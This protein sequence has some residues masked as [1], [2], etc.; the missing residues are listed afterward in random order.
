MTLLQVDAL[1]RHT[2]R[3]AA[4]CGAVTLA[5]LASPVCAT[6]PAETCVSE[7]SHSL[8]RLFVKL[9]IPGVPVCYRNTICC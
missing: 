2:K 9:L 5:S 6:S 3:M 7:L 8:I 4:M 1:G